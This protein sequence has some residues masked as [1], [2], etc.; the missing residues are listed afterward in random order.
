M[1][2]Q[3]L[4]YRSPEVLFNDRHFGAPADIFSM[5]VVLF[6]ISGFNGLK[7]PKDEPAFTEAVWMD[8]LFKCLGRPT[9]TSLSQ[10]P[11]FPKN[12][13]RHSVEPMLKALFR[14]VSDSFAVQ[15]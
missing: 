8:L 13:S 4:G 12:T 2:Y 14:T 5:G 1:Q 7:C 9:D 11:L 15:P 6:E 3:T 10:L